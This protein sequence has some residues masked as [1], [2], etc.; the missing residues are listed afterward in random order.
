[1]L[2]I[3]MQRVVKTAQRPFLQLMLAGAVTLLA[4]CTWTGGSIF[5]SDKID[6]QTAK[7]RTTSLDVPPD[8]TQLPRDERFSVPERPQSVTASAA[9]AGRTAGAA[10]VAAATSN[11]VPAG[12]IA[13]IERQGQQRWL[14]VNMPPEKAWPILVDF[15]PS[16][17]LNVE[18][19]DA[20][21]GVLET[22]WAENKANLPQD[23][24]RKTL[25]RVLDSVYSTN[26]QDKY[27]ARLERTAQDT[28]EIFVT[29][30]GMIEVFTS[31]A[32]D[33]TAWQ[34]RPPDPELE[35]EMLQRLLVRFDGK[36][37][38]PA[39]TT[40]AS[41]AAP[42]AAGAAA[43]TA[44][45]ALPQKARLIK[46][47]SGRNEK[48][49]VDDGFDRAWRQIGLALDRGGFTV[50]DRDRPKGI[51]FVRYLDPEVEAKLKAEQGWLNKLFNPDKA[52]AAPQYRVQVTSEGT[53]RT[54]VQVL[55]K[56]GKPEQTVA[57]DRILALLTEQ[58]R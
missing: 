33:R 31:T 18:K 9:A 12:A 17:G 29:H 36:S 41:A 40:V 45:T 54:V 44:T 38:A 51:F 14:V 20:A 49:E 37:A 48:M 43:A 21:T 16:V 25:G 52:V 7:T 15:W 28:S 5:S 57:A 13:R 42:V 34:P 46:G 10:P 2:E 47:T 11:V 50:E 22:N 55:D 8:L 58:L 30:K 23:I 32:Q 24:I 39:S 19:S 3:R 53:T 4:G 56:D 26:E 35:A 6:Y 27:R 1:M